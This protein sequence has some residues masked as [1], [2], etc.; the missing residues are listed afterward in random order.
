MYGIE[1]LYKGNGLVEVLTTIGV[2]YRKPLLLQSDIE[3]GFP[4]APLL[5]TTHKYLQL[6]DARQVVLGYQFHLARG[7]IG[8]VVMSMG[9][10]R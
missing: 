3:L 7:I 10:L 8:T 9:F 2:V 1:P 5:L 6:I 4:D